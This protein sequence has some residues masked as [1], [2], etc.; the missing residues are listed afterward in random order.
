MANIAM[1]IPFGFLLSALLSRRRFI[2]PAAILSSILIETLQLL[3]MRGLFEWDDVVS[4]TIGAAIGV[5]AYVLLEVV[6]KKNK[7]SIVSAV[8]ALIFT[9]ISLSVL[10]SDWNSIEA[11]SSSRAYCFQI[12][13]VVVDSMIETLK[14]CPSNIQLARYERA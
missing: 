7:L 3:L 4:N 6:L 9:V 11:D 8:I 12:D 1:F 5:G 2:I 10:I 13:D 14:V